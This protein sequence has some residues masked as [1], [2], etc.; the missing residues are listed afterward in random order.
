[1]GNQININNEARI[2]IGDQ[3]LTRSQSMAL[4]VAI[5]SEIILMDKEHQNELGAVGPLYLE[6]WREIE[7]MLRTAIASGKGV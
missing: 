6:R 2:K 7:D 5:S 1:M 4:R 3:E